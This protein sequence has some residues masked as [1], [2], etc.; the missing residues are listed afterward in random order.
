MRAASPSA[1]GGNRR[2]FVP[3][4]NHHNFYTLT[5][6]VYFFPFF[7]PVDNFIAAKR[8]TTGGPEQSGGIISEGSSGFRGEDAGGG[9][10]LKGWGQGDVVGRSRVREEKGMVLSPFSEVGCV[11]VVHFCFQMFNLR[12]SQK[13]FCKKKKNRKKEAFVF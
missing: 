9:V 5:V 2:A 12:F 8:A 3:Q 13:A 7:S 6:C 10:L 11:I 1:S 4:P